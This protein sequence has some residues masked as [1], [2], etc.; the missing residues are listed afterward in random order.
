VRPR[1]RDL[2]TEPSWFYVFDGMG[3][4]PRRTDPLLAVVEP[5]RLA[6]MLGQIGRDALAG[7][8]MAVPHAD[9]FPPSQ[10]RVAIVA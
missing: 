3:L 10:T 5:V 4:T 8:R 1:P 9:L 7:A 6:Q 2:F